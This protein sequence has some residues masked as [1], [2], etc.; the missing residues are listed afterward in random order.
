MSHS[1]D[2]MELA[3]QR[4]A[5][6]R[7]VYSFGTQDSMEAGVAPE[8]P[9]CEVFHHGTPRAQVYPFAQV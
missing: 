3:L 2:R 9:G 7:P 6:V 1:D 8:A 4:R 5:G